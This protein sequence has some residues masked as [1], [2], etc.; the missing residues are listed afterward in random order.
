MRGEWRGVMRVGERGRISERWGEW[1]DER[2]VR[3]R[4]SV[5]EWVT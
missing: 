5:R 3:V 4:L 1:R 2:R